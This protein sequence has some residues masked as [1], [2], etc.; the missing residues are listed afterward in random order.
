MRRLL[1]CT[2]IGVYHGAL[3]RGK[4]YEVLGE[5]PDGS[6]KLRGDNER[7]RWYSS[8]CFDLAGGVA[9]TLV[10]WWFE[11][12]GLGELPPDQWEDVAF[13]LSDGTY[14]WCSFVTPMYL[15]QLLESP[16]RVSEPGLWVPNVI[17]VKSLE[18]QVVDAMMRYL[19]DH[20][21]LL[22]ASNLIDDARDV[23]EPESAGA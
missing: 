23:T 1:T 2:S 12:E 3:T 18:R 19:D 10:R 6:L 7:V 15:K 20:A 11:H 9:P 5:R 14:R 17:I 21:E 13:E 22:K 4:Q 8:Y 16:H